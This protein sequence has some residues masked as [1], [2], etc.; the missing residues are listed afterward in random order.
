M[1]TARTAARARAGCTAALGVHVEDEAVVKAERCYVDTARLR[2]IGRMESP[3]SYVRTQ[4]RFRLRT[5]T[6][7]EWRARAQPAADRSAGG[8]A[9]ACRLTLCS[10]RTILPVTI[11][12]ASM[13][14]T[15]NG[16]NP[17]RHCGSRCERKTC[18][19]VA[20][21]V[22]DR[23]CDR[24]HSLVEPTLGHAVA[25]FADVAQGLAEFGACR[26]SRRSSRAGCRATAMCPWRACRRLQGCRR[27]LL[28]A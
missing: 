9:L 10:S 24:R 26:K 28:S 11:K 5:P 17:G 16:A 4:D 8:P 21:P 19:L 23:S 1:R 13:T 20:L 15:A 6:L 27:K 2:L 12:A 3:G 14:G 22:E 7:Q 25:N 18:Q